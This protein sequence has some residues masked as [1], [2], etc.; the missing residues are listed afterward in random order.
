LK[1]GVLSLKIGLQKSKLEEAI[2]IAPVLSLKT[3]L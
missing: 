2:A 1:D 3:W